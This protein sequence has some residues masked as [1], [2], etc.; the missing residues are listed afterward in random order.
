MN[1][2]PNIFT[3]NLIPKTT[4]SKPHYHQPVYLIKMGKSA[5][6]K[7]SDKTKNLSFQ[8]LNQ[9]IYLDANHLNCYFNSNNNVNHVNENYYNQILPFNSGCDSVESD[10]EEGIYLDF[11]YF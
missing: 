3:K 7:K 11:N 2:L 1:A 10:E 8:N 5:N 9:C 4:N 6:S